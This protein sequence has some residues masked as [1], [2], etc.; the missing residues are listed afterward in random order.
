[1]MGKFTP[2]RPSDFFIGRM[3]EINRELNKLE[4]TNLRSPY[5]EAIQDINKLIRD[6]R[7]VSLYD[8]EVSFFGDIEPPVIQQEPR[9][10]TPN[11]S[12]S[13]ISPNI[14]SAQGQNVNSTLPA[15]F[16]SLPTAERLK[17]IEEFFRK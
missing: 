6:N 1:M 13:S 17:I 16:A 14:I 3:A 2:T 10:T 9:I 15:N 7:N 8:G 5:L 4:G 12:A 11:L